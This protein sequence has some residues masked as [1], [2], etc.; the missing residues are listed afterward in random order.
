MTWVQQLMSNGY[1]ITEIKKLKTSD[2]DLM[3][4]AMETQVKE[5]EKETTLDKAFPLLFG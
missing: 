2:L 1:T 3:V 5:T 4:R